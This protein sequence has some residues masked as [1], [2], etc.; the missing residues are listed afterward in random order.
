MK[1]GCHDHGSGKP[2]LDVEEQHNLR[3]IGTMKKLLKRKSTK[4]SSKQLE[5]MIRRVEERTRDWS[6]SLISVIVLDKT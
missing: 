1:R 5:A 6:P 2:F 3:W 4:P